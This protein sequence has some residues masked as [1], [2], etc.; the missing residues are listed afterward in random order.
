[1]QFAQA[2][3][4]TQNRKRAYKANQTKEIIKNALRTKDK[5]ERR[6]K[7]IKSTNRQQIVGLHY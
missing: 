7:R 1:L 3:A 4:Q 2:I 5:I 6:K